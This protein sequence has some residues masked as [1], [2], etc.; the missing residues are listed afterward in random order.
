[1]GF[2]PGPDCP[3]LYADDSS[4]WPDVLCQNGSWYTCAASSP[5]FQG[6][7]G[8]NPCAAGGTC[9]KLFPATFGNVSSSYNPGS[10]IN[11]DSGQWFSCVAQDPPFQGCCVSNPCTGDGSTCS[12][13]QFP[14]SHAGSSRCSTSASTS[15]SSE[16]T[17]TSGALTTSTA[18]VTTTTSTT[19]LSSVSPTQLPSISSTASPNIARN[20]HVYFLLLSLQET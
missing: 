19:Q 1:M 13:N 9:E 16:S 15:A 20:Q 17:I 2:G 11:C 4:Y 5:A 10:D 12:G 6:C 3:G 8:S 18:P 7:C 14:F